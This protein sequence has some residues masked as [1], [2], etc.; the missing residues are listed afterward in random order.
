MILRCG[1][2]STILQSMTHQS[3]QCCVTSPPYWGLRNYDLV[4]QWTGGRTD[5]DHV[6][7]F[8]KFVRPSYSRRKH[9]LG[10]DKRLRPQPVY[11][12]GKCGKC[13][14][15]SV[16]SK[17]QIGVEPT[18]DDYVTNL[19]R[20]FTQLH[21]VL[22]DDGVFWL[23]IGDTYRSGELC[24]VPWRVVFAL[25]AAGWRLLSDVV[26]D[27]PNAAPEGA[28]NRLSHS[29][30]YLFMLA[31]TENHRFYPERIREAVPPRTLRIHDKAGNI[32]QRLVD[33]GRKRRSVWSIPT[34][35]VAG[36]SATFPPELVELC[37]LS[38]TDRGDWVLDPFSGSG[39]TVM[40]CEKLKRRGIGIDLSE[41]YLALSRKRIAEG[42]KS[43]LVLPGPPPV[44]SPLE[45]K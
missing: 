31:K 16:K 32:I 37:V 14:A 25:Q 12:E 17:S 45:H 36:H 2:A 23:N 18:L 5:C 41:A 6:E 43:R 10:L 33:D 39:T 42:Y 38:S 1:D 40:V 27:K 28:K 20:I 13:G 8:D 3:V 4:P 22:R 44:K 26:W 15:V 11:Y 30:E 24:G 35:R 19:V 21:S 29:H 34:Q 9:E 7:K